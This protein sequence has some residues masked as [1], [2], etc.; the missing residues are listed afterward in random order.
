MNP[1][2]M[3]FDKEA[4]VWDANPGRVKLAH[5]V[6]DAIIRELKPTQDLDVLDFGC[7]TGLVTLRLQPLVRSITGVDSSQ[8]MLAVLQDKVKK[9]GLPNVHPRFDDFQSGDRVTGQFHL[10]VSSMTMHHVPDIAELLRVWFDLLLPDGRLSVADLDKED[11]SFHGD[12]TGVYHLGFE[13]TAVKE[14]F[15][16]IGFCEV[17]AMTAASMVKEIAGKGNREFTV[18]LITG[19]K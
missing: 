7:G 5:D 9:Q 4:A 12:N 3:D 19:R 10:L 11:G 15:E 16:E 2:G 17:R 18:F 6:A 14:L 1:L 13:R 8:G